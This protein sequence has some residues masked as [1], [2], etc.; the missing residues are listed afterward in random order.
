MCRKRKDDG[1]RGARLDIKH[2][3]S[4]QKMQ[5]D[6]EADDAVMNESN[7]DASN[8]DAANESMMKEQQETT[9][10]E[11]RMP[12]K[13]LGHL[14][15]MEDDS[16][17]KQS[18]EKMPDAAE[19]E[20]K[21]KKMRNR[22]PEG[23]RRLR[24]DDQHGPAEKNSERFKRQA[25]DRAKNEARLKEAENRRYEERQKLIEEKKREV[26]QR[27]EK[28]KAERV[29]CLLLVFFSLKIKL[30]HVV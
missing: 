28:Q 8:E 29:S 12:E 30:L 4:G 2:R 7:I 1:T 15:R 27:L 19:F 11:R 18:P 16:L 13:R 24:E 21:E 5:L 25:E 3:N 22:K 14:K 9:N 17:R 20:E 23:V 6:A 10:D 26:Q